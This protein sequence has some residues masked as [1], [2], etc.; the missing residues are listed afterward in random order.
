MPNIRQFSVGMHYSGTTCSQLFFLRFGARRLPSFLRRNVVKKEKPTKVTQY[1]RDIVCL[2]HSFGK[3]GL[4]SITIPRGKQ[5]IRLAELGLQ[6]KVTLSSDMTEEAML[7]EVRSA[8]AEAMGH[9]PCFPFT[10][11]Q[12]SGSGTKTLAVPSL[13]ASFRWTPQEVCKL[14][15]TCVYILSEK[16]LANEVF[17]H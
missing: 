12:V 14:G 5:R 1:N 6:G 2:P 4:K 8:F 16:K 15:R 9:D 7:D 13:S 3:Q 17:L 10:F 11:L